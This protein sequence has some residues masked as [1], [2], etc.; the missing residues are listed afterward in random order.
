MYKLIVE[1]KRIFLVGGLSAILILLIVL[2]PLSSWD[3]V[4]IAL[5]AAFFVNGPHFAVSYLLFYRRYRYAVA[6][7]VKRLTV[8]VVLPVILIS[9]C[10]LGIVIQSTSPLVFLFYSMTILVGLHYVK[11]GFG[12]FIYE[13]ARHKLFLNVSERALLLAA[14]Y[15]L[16]IGSL[17]VVWS[18][19]NRILHY[20]DLEIVTISISSDFLG[21]G[22]ALLVGSIVLCV[23]SLGLFAKRTGGI[24][25][26]G[27]VGVLIQYL[28]V[29]PLGYVPEVIYVI[30]FFHS[31]QYLLISNEAVHRVDPPEALGGVRHFVK[32]WGMAFVLGYLGFEFIPTSIDTMGIVTLNAT[33]ALVSFIFVI[34][35]HHY[36]IDGVIWTKKSKMV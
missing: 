3:W 6:L 32:W 22:Y 12:V 4:H 26:S 35:I 9:V 1:P 25:L 5:I 28:W 29:A 17:I 34:N 24:S 2:T 36:F 19:V 20:Y 31:L 16:W 11:Q 8:G 14:M 13:N 33:Y 7:P 23:T 27:A 15:L 30:P 18:A 21:V 10:F